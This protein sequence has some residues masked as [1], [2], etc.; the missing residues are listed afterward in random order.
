MGVS[1]ITPKDK[2]PID[3]VPSVESKAVSTPKEKK[4]GIDL[5]AQPTT[6]GPS[7]IGEWYTRMTQPAVS[8]D[9]AAAAASGKSPGEIASA[10]TVHEWALLSSTT[11][12][13]ATPVETDPEC[14]KDWEKEAEIIGEGVGEELRDR[15]KQIEVPVIRHIVAKEA[16]EFAKEEVKSAAHKSAV[17]SCKTPADPTKFTK[18]H[19]PMSLPI[20][21]PVPKAKPPEPLFTP[22]DPSKAVSK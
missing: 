3:T 15:I 9:C 16:K 1:S 20:S 8:T 19:A 11:P 4:P 17:A 13:G 10:C 22:A 2:K 18:A 5:D 14:V 7:K 12:Q 6:T 21:S